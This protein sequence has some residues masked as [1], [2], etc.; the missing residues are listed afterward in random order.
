VWYTVLGVL[1]L[2]ATAITWR[3]GGN[4]P[5]G[6]ALVFPAGTPDFPQPGSYADVNWAGRWEPA[7]I[8]KHERDEY[9]VRQV[10]GFQHEA[11]RA[12]LRPLSP[13]T[14]GARDL[15]GMG[16][17]RRPFFGRDARLFGL[18]LGGLMAVQGAAFLAIRSV[19]RKT[20]G[21]PSL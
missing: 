19:T 9:T 21:G 11:T 12:E 18:I 10:G 14:Y 17:V 13:S 20:T 6:D 16:P 1:V 5:A 7:I 8:L 2:M 4:E 15:L 3:L